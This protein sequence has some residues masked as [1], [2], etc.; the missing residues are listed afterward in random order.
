[1]IILMEILTDKM[2]N[3]NSSSSLTSFLVA[4]YWTIQKNKTMATTYPMVFLNHTTHLS[5]TY[6]EEIL[7]EQIQKNHTPN[8][9]LGLE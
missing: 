2:L 1:M 9:V 5:V 7:F 6:V 8:T 4:N 3:I